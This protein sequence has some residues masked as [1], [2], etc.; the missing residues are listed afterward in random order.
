MAI[1]TIAV[2][3]YELQ[4]RGHLVYRS[5]VAVRALERDQPSDPEVEYMLCADNPQVIERYP[6]ESQERGRSLLIWGIMDYGRIGHIVCS[7]PPNCY[8]ITTY[9]PD[10][11]A[12]QWSSD[13][14]CRIQ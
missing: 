9:W 3:C 11:R 2:V 7:C 10:S 14:K 5:H 4:I 13:F 8:V 12:K 6:P 1:D